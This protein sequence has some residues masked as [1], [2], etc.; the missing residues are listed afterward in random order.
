MLLI[1][2]ASPLNRVLIRPDILF[3]LVRHHCNPCP[4][5][6]IFSHHYLVPLLP[7]VSLTHSATQLHIQ[8]LYLLRQQGDL[9]LV[10]GQPPS[11]FLQADSVGLILPPQYLSLAQLVLT[12]SESLLCLLQITNLYL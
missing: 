1:L 6:L 12:V 2:T 11:L 5:L 4:I 8:P 7:R 3:H 10:V 9:V